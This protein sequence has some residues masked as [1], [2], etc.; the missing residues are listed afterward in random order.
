MRAT[1]CNGP[2]PNRCHR[3]GSW[4][5]GENHKLGW[6][7]HRFLILLPE[8]APGTRLWSPPFRTSKTHP[9]N[10]LQNSPV[11]SAS[12]IILLSQPASR[13]DLP[14][15][16]A[17]LQSWPASRIGLFPCPALLVGLPQRPGPFLTSPGMMTLEHARFMPGSPQGRTHPL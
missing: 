16:P 3:S 5:I 11:Q 7:S 8:P 2:K 4:S 17:C 1:G 14:P 13:T 15:G 6:R 9:K 10:L 12:R